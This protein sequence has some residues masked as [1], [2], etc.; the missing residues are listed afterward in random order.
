MK[1]LKLQNGLS[2]IDFKIVEDEI[3][4]TLTK[5]FRKLGIIAYDDIPRKDYSLLL[6][7]YTLYTICKT[8]SK[9]ENKRNTIFFIEPDKVHKDIFGFI[10]DIQK[11]L[12]IPMFF[13]E[14]PYNTLISDNTAEYKETSSLIKDYRYNMDYSKYSFNKIKLFCKKHKLNSL[15]EDFKFA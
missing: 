10:K 13:S 3:L 15:L 9:V 14:T 11:V 12:P 2:V 6:K 5:E 8:Q 4:H 7:Y 1:L